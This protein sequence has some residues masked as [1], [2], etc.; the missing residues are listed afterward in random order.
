MQA[1]ALMQVLED[2]RLSAQILWRLHLTH[3]FYLDKEDMVFE[4]LCNTS[5]TCV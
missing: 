3:C 4:Q 5:D 2:E 1:P